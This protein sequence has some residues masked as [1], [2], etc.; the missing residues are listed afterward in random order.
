MVTHGF[1]NQTNAPAKTHNYNCNVKDGGGD[2][3]KDDIFY[4][5]GSAG[6]YLFSTDWLDPKEHTKVI[7][8]ICAYESLKK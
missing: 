7:F 1:R 8:Q 3:D 5:T 6:R 4:T 2:F